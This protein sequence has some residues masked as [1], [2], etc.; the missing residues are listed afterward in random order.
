M[1]VPTPLQQA[2]AALPTIA[3][4]GLCQ[5]SCGPVAWSE[6]EAS[7][8]S[9]NGVQEPRTVEHPRL[10]PM[11]CSHLTQAGRCAI[12]EDRPLVC[13]LFGVVREMR[14]PHGCRP[15]GGTDDGFLAEST[16]RELLA[17]LGGMHGCSV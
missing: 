2:R 10:G 3:C 9:N 8:W 14:C 17:S 12:Y 11:T 13:R 15:Q 5:A 16:S 7:A 6:A 4:K 1:T